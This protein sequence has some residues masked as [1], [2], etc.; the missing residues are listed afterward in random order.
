[1]LH[2]LAQVIRQVVAAEV[3][4]AAGDV[5]AGHDAVAD[6]QPAAFA[7]QHGAPNGGDPAHILVA[8]DQRIGEFA[9]VRRAGILL[10]FATEGVLV[11][12]ANAGIM[13]LH[14]HR[15][16]LRLGQRELVHGDAAGPFGD[17]GADHVHA[18]LVR[19]IS[20]RPDATLTG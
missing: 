15:A 12:A 16:R 2:V 19:S 6:F 10:V 20:T 14:Q 4:V 1:V 3:A 17:G 5:G 13:H 18:G 8:A 11:G 9:L 7:V